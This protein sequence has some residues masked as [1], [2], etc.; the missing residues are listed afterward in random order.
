MVNPLLSKKYSIDSEY[1]IKK[2]LKYSNNAK[3]EFACNQ[4]TILLFSNYLL[5]YLKKKI[6]MESKEWLAPYHPYAS[7]H[8]YKGIYKG[9]PISVIMPPMGASPIASVAEDLITCGSKVLLLVCGAWG[10]AQNVKLLDFLIPTHAIGPDGTSLHYGR[11]PNEKTMINK[12]IVAIFSEETSK[13]TEN[14]HIGKNYSMEAFYRIKLKKVID[15]QNKGFISMENGELNTL[16]TICS[17][18]QVK[19]GAIFYSYYNLLENW[20]VPWF[21]EDY[22]KCVELEGKITLATIK[23][24]ANENHKD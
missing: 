14:Y 5:D 23:R 7:H 17:Q 8:L 2:A 1:V 10:I 21:Q 6:N 13:R 22:K 4:Y 15:L 12:E 9:I 19:F 24:L 18:K 3:E 16:A 11:S 20:M